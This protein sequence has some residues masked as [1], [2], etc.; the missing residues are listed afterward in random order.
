MPAISLV[1]VMLVAVGACESGSEPQYEPPEVGEHIFT[2]PSVSPGVSG[3]VQPAK[4]DCGKSDGCPQ[5]GWCKKV[6]YGNCKPAS[7]EDCEQSHGCAT[8]RLC[9]LHEGNCVE[10]KVGGPRGVLQCGHSASCRF[11]G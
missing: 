5:F 3:S 11:H 2:P 4:V 1:V 9:V 6:G 10:E 7:H 8:N